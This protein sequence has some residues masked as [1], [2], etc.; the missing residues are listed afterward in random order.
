MSLQSFFQANRSLAIRLT[1]YLP[2]ATTHPFLLYE[3]MVVRYMHQFPQPVILD[4]GGGTECCFSK[5]KPPG[6]RIISV[7]ISSAQ[8]A[9]NRDADLL[10]LADVTRDIP[11]PDGSVDLVVSRAVMEH[12]TSPRAFLHHA[13]RVLKPGGYCIHVFPCRFALFATIN[14]GLPQH[15]P[16]KFLSTFQPDIHEKGG[17]PAYYRQCYPSA[18]KRLLQQGGFQI[19]EMVPYYFQS[20]YFDFFLPFFLVSALYELATRGW[21]DLAAFLLIAAKKPADV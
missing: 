18:M 8:L 16:R 21:V 20:V 13:Y 5:H 1:R 12:L 15:L 7:D 19:R 9:Q 17:F 4:V 14:R 11:L 2:Q 3:E 6:G 10:M